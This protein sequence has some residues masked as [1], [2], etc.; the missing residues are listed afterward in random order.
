MTTTY[1]PT[2]KSF[3]SVDIEPLIE[4]HCAK[5]GI[6]KARALSAAE[7]LKK[8]LLLCA[9]HPKENFPMLDGD[10]DDMW[11]SAILYSPIY[12]SLCRCTGEAYIHHVPCA[13]PSTEFRTARPKEDKDNFVLRYGRFVEAYE[14]EFGRLSDSNVYWPRAVR[15]EHENCTACEVSRPIRVGV[16]GIRG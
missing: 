8:W 14:N 3:D 11:H 9:L 5:F 15:K 2:L 10:V 16:C 4:Y 12:W 6:E 1:R 7:E 13:E